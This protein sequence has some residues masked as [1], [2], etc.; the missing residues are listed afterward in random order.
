MP[1]TREQ[2]A[3]EKRSK[4]SE[5][6]SDIEIM[7]NMEGNFPGNDFER[8]EITGK[9]EADLETDRLHRENRM[10]GENFRS[11]SNTNISVNNGFIAETSRAVN[12]EIASQLFRKL[13]EVRIDLKAHVVEAI[14]SAIEEKV[15][16][17]IQNPLNVHSKF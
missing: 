8:Q 13:E 5:V 1:S 2:K 6:M 9:I 17:T 16:P 7:D 3:S 12:S 15:L 4:H 10:T 14:N 11:L